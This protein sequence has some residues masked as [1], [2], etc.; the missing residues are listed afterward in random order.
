MWVFISKVIG[1]SITRDIS[2]IME[3]IYTYTTSNKNLF[4]ANV[5]STSRKL[6]KVS[7]KPVFF[8]QSG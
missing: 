8:L 6:S 4:H 7:Y 1:E 2:Y 3:Y 5:L